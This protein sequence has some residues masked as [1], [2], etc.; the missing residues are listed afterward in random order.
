MI[1]MMNVTD[2]RASMSMS[3]SRIFYK[4]KKHLLKQNEISLKDG[5]CVYRGEDGLTCAVGCLIPDGLYGAQMERHRVT[6]SIV[7]GSLGSV[8]GLNPHKRRI[9]I[10][11]L[12]SLQHL[13]DA[14]PPKEW[15]KELDEL[16]V[17]YD[18]PAES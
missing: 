4:V 9:K 11:L 5:V 3:M 6:D 7:N 17:M 2:R 13:H 15:P 10:G 18:I 12:R 14:F 1:S 16:Q 8:I